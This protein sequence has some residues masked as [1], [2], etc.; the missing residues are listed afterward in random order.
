M[1][2]QQVRAGD[3]ALLVIA[4]TRELAV[5]IQEESDKFGRSSDIKTVCCY[6]GAPKGP[7][8]SDIRSGVHGVIG[9]PGRIND[10]LEAG[11]LQLGNIWKLVLDEADRML[12]M[13]FEPQ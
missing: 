8:A 11:Q 3:P 9:T 10:F 1:L 4:P 5:Q 12:D 7:Q 13:G 6:G 2:S